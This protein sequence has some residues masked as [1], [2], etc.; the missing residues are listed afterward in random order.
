MP[1][2]PS[3]FSDLVLIYQQEIDS[4][5][6]NLGKDITLYF[7]STITNV[8]SEFQDIVRP[9]EIIKPKYKAGTENNKPIITE[10]VRTIKALIKYNPKN[11]SDFDIRLNESRNVIRLKT[12]LSDVPDI[13]RCEYMMPNVDSK[14]ILYTKYTLMK[15]PVPVGLQKDRYAISWWERSTN[16]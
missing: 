11:Y 8:T 9:G 14:H 1:L 2:D 12:Y 3:T 5:I 15:E 16:G 4:L 10:N 13:L 6:D 7:P